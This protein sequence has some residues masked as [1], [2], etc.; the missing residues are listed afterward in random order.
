MSD[1]KRTEGEPHD[2][3]TRIANRV[4]IQVELDPEWRVGGK[5]IVL[6]NDGNR[7]GVGLFGYD[8]DTEAMADMLIHIRG[9]LRA[10]GKDLQV[11]PM[12]GGEMS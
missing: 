8:S 6:L 3:L 10:H 11:H 9:I 2:R 1:E 4:G 5:A 12:R 7:A